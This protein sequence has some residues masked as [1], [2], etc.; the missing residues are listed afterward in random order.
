[1]PYLRTLEALCGASASTLLIDSV[2]AHGIDTLLAHSGEV[3]PI[4]ELASWEAATTI[5]TSPENNPDP[6]APRLVCY[7]SQQANGCLLRIASGD[8]SPPE[9]SHAGEGTPERRSTPGSSLTVTSD[10]VWIGLQFEAEGLP[11]ELEQLGQPTATVPQTNAQWLSHLFVLVANM[12]QEINHLARLLRDPTSHLP[13]RAEF[14][15]Q[16]K[17]SF[18]ETSD[19]HQHLGLLLINPDEFGAINQRLDRESGDRALAE[20]ALNLRKGLRHTDAVFRYGGAVF[21]VLMPGATVPA[22]ESVA[23]KVRESLTGAYLDGAVRLSFSVGGVVF[24]PERELEEL[25]DE[26]VLLRQADHALNLAKRSGGGCVVFW[27]PDEE[28][29]T[30]SG[31]D[32]LSGIFTADTV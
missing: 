7:R 6:D 21:A 29:A 12:M 5:A 15:T 20:I 31:L 23:N 22:V 1:M 16:L 14:Q 9:E 18:E 28:D 19:A 30:T 3:P 26:L 24:D 25:E 17:N 27:N 4:P 32:R 10:T 8:S 2:G 13:G 11:P